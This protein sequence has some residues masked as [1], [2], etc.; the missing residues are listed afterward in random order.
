M[1]IKPN[2][3]KFI[4]AGDI[5]SLIKVLNRRNGSIS[6]EAAA[7]L[8]E[9]RDAAGISPLLNVINSDSAMELK[10]CAT[11]ALLRFSDADLIQVFQ[12]IANCDN[13]QMQDLILI[14][15]PFAKLLARA[16]LSIDSERAE[17]N[18]PGWLMSVAWIPFTIP[19]D[20]KPDQ[21]EALLLANL[22]NWE[23]C[24]KAGLDALK[25]IMILI[26]YRKSVNTRRTVD[27][28]VSFGKQAT[29]TI[30]KEISATWPDYRNTNRS[31]LFSALA[32]IN[33]QRVI[34]DLIGML[35]G[36][37]T[38][39][40]KDA[41]VTLEK[42]GWSPTSRGQFHLYQL[43]QNGWR[44]GDDIATIDE[45]LDILAEK[46]QPDSEAVKLVTEVVARKYPGDAPVTK[47]CDCGFP[48]I[49]QILDRIF[50]YIEYEDYASRN[51]V[52]ACP[53]CLK[54]IS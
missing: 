28:L 29:E 5:A 24:L 50:V 1:F 22:D 16:I 52:F 35:S 41:A 36:V 48:I 39:L 21:A 14:G 17:K 2:I 23:E 33:D 47:T 51:W 27:A 42:L 9:L 44:P 26:R 30:V 8:G 37:D 45:I 12:W 43:A 6:Q 53:N 34:P 25:P 40:R 31:I 13:R 4:K 3:S 10:R 7:A 46:V 11:A 32:E 18:N 20:H 38:L 49:N 19:P 54:R 15:P